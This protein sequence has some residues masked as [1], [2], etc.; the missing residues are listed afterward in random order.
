MRFRSNIFDIIVNILCVIQL[1]GIVLYLIITWSS[2]PDQIPGHFNAAGEVTRW[3]GKISLIF[4]PILA[5]VLFIGMSVL[6]RFPQVWN[7]G[8]RIT[9]EN[10][11][12]VYRVLKN[13]LRT[14]KLLIVTLFVL[15]TIFQSLAQS[16]PVWCLPVFLSLLFVFIIYNIFRLLRAR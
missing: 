10:K 2:I 1:V 15:I 13:L 3:D 9:E 12:R 16:M 4:L 11:F 8:V 6:E 14:V 7:T 5:W